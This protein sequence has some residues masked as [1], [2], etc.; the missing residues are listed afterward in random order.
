MLAPLN[1]SRAETWAA[2]DWLTKPDGDPGWADWFLARGYELYIVDVPFRGRS[3]WD[4][5]LGDALSFTAEQ[6]REMFTACAA[7]G[8]WPQAPLHTQWPGTGDLGDPAFDRLVASGVPM[9]RGQAAQEAA[10]RDAVVALVDRVARPVVL[11]AHSNGGGVPYLVADARPRLVRLV[12]ALEPKGPPFSGGR[13]NPG[14]GNRWGVCQVPISWAPPVADPAVDLVT[15]TRKAPSPDLL[16]ATLQADDPPP[17]RLVNLTHIPVL[18]VTAPA[19]FHAQYDWCTVEFLRQAGVPAEHMKLEE[20]GILGNG[21]MMFMEKNSDVVAA[22]V[23][24]WIAGTLLQ[25]EAEER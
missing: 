11:L 19:S 10:T 5:A 7:H 25:L 6:V 9:L 21:H 18:V 24:R 15:V 2:Q 17:R 8:T 4:P 12:V 20:R 23:E 13:Y 16:D 22:E 1:D 3:A 14:L